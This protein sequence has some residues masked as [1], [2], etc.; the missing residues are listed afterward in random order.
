[1]QRT[2]YMFN[3]MSRIGNDMSDLSQ[4]NVQNVKQGNY[5]LENP[6]PSDL[7]M[8]SG[9]DFALNQP[10]FNYTG[11]Y[12]TS[13]NGTN[14]ETSSKLLIDKNL[15]HDKGKISLQERQYLTIPYLGKGKVETDLET[16]LRTGAQ[17][18]HRKTATKLSE[19]SFIPLQNTPMIPEVASK[20]QN[21]SNLIEGAA[22]SG[23]IRGG[24]P[25]R[26]YA[27]KQLN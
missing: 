3:G 13:L 17:E 4:K 11:T 5:Q 19:R 23:W 9:M 22:S 16:K 12:Q 6:Y 20:I 25:S 18:T 24:L 7:E 2:D 14:V 15:L 26:E 21:P 8:K 1:M 10:M 27:K